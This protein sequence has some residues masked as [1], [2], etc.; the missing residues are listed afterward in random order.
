MRV[1]IFGH[2]RLAASQV[3]VPPELNTVR[4]A[5][6]YLSVAQIRAGEELTSNDTPDPRF[7]AIREAR[8]RFKIPSIEF[9]NG[10]D[11]P[12]FARSRILPVAVRFAWR[13]G[14]CW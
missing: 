11:N 2:G 10:K 6:C 13:S 9:L 1:W 8:A 12:R 14:Q 7:P 4:H 3:T 5:L